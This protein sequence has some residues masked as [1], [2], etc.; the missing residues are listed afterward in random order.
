MIYLSL[1]EKFQSLGFFFLIISNFYYLKYSPSMLRHKNLLVCYG[2]VTK[3]KEETL[4]IT[5]WIGNGDLRKLL[6]SSDIELTWPLKLSLVI[7]IAKG[8]KFLHSLS[9]V[10]GDLKSQNIMVIKCKIKKT[11]IFITLL[12]LTEDYIAK[13]IDF[14]SCAI[15]GTISETSVGTTQWMAPECFD[16]PLR[17]HQ[18]LDSYS[19]GVKLMKKKT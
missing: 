7:G 4:I 17:I 9:L 13:I 19:F 15:D 1:E 12:Q 6:T 3:L 8:M 16:L 2:A 14:G 18:Q 5:E 11:L 10:H